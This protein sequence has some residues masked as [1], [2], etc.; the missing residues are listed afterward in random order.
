MS[1]RLGQTTNNQAGNC[2]ACDRTYGQNFARVYEIAICSREDSG[3]FTVRL[4][5]KCWRELKKQIEGI[6][7]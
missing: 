6:E 7:K 3:G 5:P 2:S 1:V 4:C